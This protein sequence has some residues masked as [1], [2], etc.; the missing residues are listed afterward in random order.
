MA[1]SRRPVFAVDPACLCGRLSSPVRA[2]AL[3]LVLAGTAAH[4]GHEV[5]YYPSFYPQEIR[6]EPLDPERAAV[7]FANT[8]DPLHAYLGAAPRFTGEAPAHIKSA[9]SLGSFITARIDPQRVPDRNARCAAVA[10]AVNALM[11]KPDV[12]PHRYPVTPYHADYLGHVDHT[13]RAKPA[14]GA[15]TSGADV[16]FDEVTTDQVLA[17]AGVPFAGWPAPPWAKEGWFQAYHLLKD[18]ISDAADGKHADAA[19]G[20]LADGEFRDPAERLNLERDLIAA[21]TRGCEMSVVAYRLRREFYSDDFSGGI[22]NILVDLQTGFNSPVFVRT[23][24]LKDFPWNGW[25]RLGIAERPQAAW[26]PVAGFT[27]APGRLV[28]SALGDNAFLPIPHNSRWVAN[29]VEVRPEEE[30]RQ[31]VAARARRCRD[32]GAP[33]PAGSLRS[34]RRPARPPRSRIASS[35]PRSTTAPRWRRR[36]CSTP[37][38]S[39]SAGDRAT[40]T[41]CSTRRSPP[42]RG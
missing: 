6:I 2:G 24:K 8:A 12:V 22:E 36:T 27:D 15:D 38:R 40:P 39:R 23:V 20:R 19:Y 4:A 3:A 33:A 26:N 16:R 11:A 32:A 42:R 37:T 18:A 29:R 34:V 31:A 41:A 10:N 21:L 1:F 5:P 13:A 9:V 25:L 35:L 14:A 28:W 7:E 17:K 30:K